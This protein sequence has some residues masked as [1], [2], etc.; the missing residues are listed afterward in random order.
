M[1]MYCILPFLVNGATAAAAAFGN[2][3]IQ[4]DRELT[5]NALIPVN[6]SLVEDRHVSG[7][8]VVNMGSFEES[9]FLPTH[10]GSQSTSGNLTIPGIGN[11]NVPEIFL[12][13]QFPR[14]NLGFMNLNLHSSYANALRSFLITPSELVVRPYS[15]RS[16]CARASE[17]VEL[18]LF[19]PTTPR[20][21]V[22][23]ANSGQ[24]VI[25]DTN[26]R[27]DLSRE[28]YGNFMAEI[29]EIN[30]QNGIDVTTFPNSSSWFVNNC[31]SDLLDEVWPILSFPIETANGGVYNLEFTPKDYIRVVGDRCFI[32]VRESSPLYPD[33]FYIGNNL[34]E[35]YAVDFYS[36]PVPRMG[37]CL[38]AP[39]RV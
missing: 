23:I 3:P 34:F 29:N 14:P 1:I 35:K 5:R 25:I 9:I 32:E 21:I 16:Y 38:A 18:N 19:E 31:D 10:L 27:I 33:V 12:V 20:W 22:R 7:L 28:D 17:Y 13:S 39:P 4:R 30:E 26:K 24:R 15:A 6:I 37:I 36:G 11:L 2:V 8:V